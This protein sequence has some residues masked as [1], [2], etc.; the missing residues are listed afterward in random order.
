MK[1]IYFEF[2][3]KPGRQLAYK[4]RKEREK[5]MIEKIHEGDNVIKTMILFKKSFHNFYSN[6]YKKQELDMYKI[7]EYQQRQHLPT[8]SQAQ[9]QLINDLVTTF[10]ISKN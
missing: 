8:L 9:R 6:L 10:K 3:I 7:D 2:A 5:R 1:Q 4:L